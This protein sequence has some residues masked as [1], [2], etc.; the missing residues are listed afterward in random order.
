MSTMVPLV[1]MGLMPFNL[2]T[3]DDVVTWFD[4]LMASFQV[5][6][7]RWSL[8]FLHVDVPLVSLGAEILGLEFP[9]TG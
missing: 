8:L 2:S 5:L 6:V 7:L 1:A 9:V 4:C 3:E